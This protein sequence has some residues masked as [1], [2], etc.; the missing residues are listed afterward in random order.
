MAILGHLLN[1]GRLYGTGPWPRVRF[2]ESWELRPLFWR[3]SLAS[4]PVIGYKQN[5][6]WDYTV[7]GVAI[8]RSG[9]PQFR[10]RSLIGR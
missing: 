1:M 4:M 7:M 3:S 10:G 2:R 9:Y 6:R 5:T 8:D